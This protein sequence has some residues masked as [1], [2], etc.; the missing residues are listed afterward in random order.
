MIDVKINVD[1]AVS[2]FQQLDAKL[3]DA[4]PMFQ[5]V[6][7][8]L[9]AETEGNFAAQGRPDW[10]PLSEATKHNR[11]KRNR[12]SNLLKILQD[13]GILAASVSSDFGSNFA[14][15][16]AGGA[17]NDYA[18]IQQLGGNAG[19]GLAVKIPA[20]PYLPFF[21]ADDNATLQPSAERKLL[22]ILTDYIDRATAI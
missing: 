5:E 9:E 11:L 6:V 2:L 22:D 13:R 1:K 18:A 10:V 14:I 15:I 16:G 7:G 8:M 19:R 4:S 12:G 17:A 3:S 20:R 21:G